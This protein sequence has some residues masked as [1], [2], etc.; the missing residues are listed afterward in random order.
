MTSYI[1]TG[2][3]IARD[4]HTCPVC[5]ATMHVSLRAIG[6]T[7]AIPDH[8]DTLAAREA[9]IEAALTA[10]ARSVRKLVRC[11]G[12]KE[13]SIFPVAMAWLRVGLWFAA[14]PILPIIAPGPLEALWAIP[15]GLAAGGISQLFRE[16]SRFRRADG[17]LIIQ[18]SAATRA[19]SERK[20]R[21]R[22]P[23]AALPEARATR[24]PA[25]APAPAA[26]PALAAAPPPPRLEASAE[27]RFLGAAE[28]AE[29]EP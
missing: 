29:R 18:L 14:V 17:A 13:R 12:C 9:A 21:D 11:P 7:E 10:D 26:T 28:P 27:P 4:V 3:A 1:Y 23:R 16:R 25:A 8:Q 15:L 19:L 20:P 2:Q 24:V 22:A 6:H 5:R